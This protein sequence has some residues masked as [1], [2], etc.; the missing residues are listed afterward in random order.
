MKWTRPIAKLIFAK[1]LRNWRKISKWRMNLVGNTVRWPLSFTIV[2]CST[3]HFSTMSFSSNL[4][5]QGGR[6]GMRITSNRPNLRLT[7][8]CRGC[9]APCKSASICCTMTVRIVARLAVAPLNVNSQTRT[10]QQVSNQRQ[11]S[12]RWSRRT[13][14]LK[15]S[16]RCYPAI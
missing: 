13:S 14:S 7:S 10:G 12:W 9:F 2:Q 3:A 1:Y 15:W 8:T 4:M 6:I 16:A 11:R 5:V